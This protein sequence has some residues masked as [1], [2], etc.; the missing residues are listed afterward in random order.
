MNSTAFDAKFH[1]YTTILQSYA[2]SLTR[3][4]E[5]SRDLF[6]ETAFRAFKN[7]D[8][9]NEGTNFKAWLM[10]IMKN[11]F[12]N[13]Y[14]RKAKQRTLYDGTENLHFINSGEQTVSNMGTSEVMMKELTTLVKELED[15]IRIP[16]E[17]H[18]EGYKYQEI[19][20]RF[21][22]PLGTIK[23]RIFIA[24]KELKSKLKSRFQFNDLA[25]MN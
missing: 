21:D 10:T 2:Y 20:D 4:L 22:V 15:P 12:I 1:H 23:S 13:G 19:A 14:R 11:I 17:M 3:D 25:S 18:F 7:M 24:R 9:F 8:K 16:F 5:N 6:Q